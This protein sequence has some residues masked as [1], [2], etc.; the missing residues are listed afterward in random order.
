MPLVRGQVIGSVGTTGNAGGTPHLH[1]EILHGDAAVSWWTGV[2]V[3]PYPLLA[4]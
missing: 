2:P 4:P 1:F 3:N